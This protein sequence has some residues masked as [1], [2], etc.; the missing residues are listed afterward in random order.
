MK[1]VL[2]FISD[3]LKTVIIALIIVIP[4]RFFLFQPFIV[5]GQSME[6]NFKTGNYLI[7]DELSY[8]FRQ[9]QRGEIIVFKYPKNPSQRYIKRIVGLPGE[10]IE[11]KNSEVLISGKVLDE[12]KYLSEKVKTKLIDREILPN[13]EFTKITLGK[14]EYFVLGDNRFFSYDSRYW[15]SVPKENIIGRVFI[16]LWPLIQ[17]KIY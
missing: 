15:G 4:I 2:S 1:K 10:E 16:R 5:Q 14:N 3:I 9:P 6:P 12:S 13:Y 8:R 11:I 7:V 17:T